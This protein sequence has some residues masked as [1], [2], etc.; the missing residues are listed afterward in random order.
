MRNVLLT[1]CAVCLMLTGCGDETAFKHLTHDEA[2]KMIASNPDVI[3]LDVRTP[4]EFEK[5]HVFNA[6]LLPIEDLR[7]GDFSKLPDKNATILVYCWTGRRAQDSAQIL[8]DN[9]YKNVYEFGGIVDWV[10]S[11]A[12][13]NLD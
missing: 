2:R 8:I 5:K 1:I 11:V 7:E 6:V 13:T 10:G 12:G 9:G 4:Q 3:I